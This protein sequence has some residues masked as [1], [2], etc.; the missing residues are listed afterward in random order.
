MKKTSF[1][2]VRMLRCLCLPAV[3]LFA[4]N[5]V[6]AQIA[7]NDNVQ[8]SVPADVTDCSLTVTPDMISEGSNE[9]GYIQIYDNS[10]LIAE[11]TSA[12]FD[13][14]SYLGESL[15]ARVYEGTD[16]TGLFCW[17]SFTPEDKSGPT[18]SMVGAIDIDCDEDI[19]VPGDGIVATDNCSTVAAVQLAD[20]LI[21]DSDPCDDGVAIL[22]RTYIAFDDNGNA[23]APIIQDITINRTGDV[24]FPAD[25]QFNCEQYLADPTI[26]DEGPLSTFVES[27]GLTPITPGSTGLIRDL[28]PFSTAVIAG[29]SAGEVG[30]ASGLYC[31]YAASSTEDTLFVCA[32]SAR[33]F[34]IA[35]TFSVLDWCTGSLLSGASLVDA[36]GDDN[37]QIIKVVDNTDPIITGLPTAPVVVSAN[38]PGQHPVPCT[39]TGAIP[40]P[41]VT[42]CASLPANI[43]LNVFA[44]RDNNNNGLVDAGDDNVGAGIVN[45]T[46]TVITLGNAANPAQGLT[47]GNYVLRYSAGDQC[48]NVADATIQLV[49]V[50]NIQ[51][52]PVC[53]EI[54]TITL[55][56]S[57]LATIPAT[58]FDDGSF[59]NCCLE[60]FLVGKLNPN[61]MTLVPDADP[62]DDDL[63]NSINNQFSSPGNIATFDN[64]FRGTS[65][66]FDCDDVGSNMVELLVYDC[67]GNFNTCM[68]EVIVEDKSLVNLTCPTFAP[69]NCLDFDAIAVQLDATDPDDNAGR[70]AI[71]ESFGFASPLGFGAICGQS[72]DSQISF[73][74]DN[75]GTGTITRTFTTTG[76]NMATASIS[77]DIPVT[78]VPTFRVQ[79]PGDV[80]EVCVDGTIIDVTDTDLLDQLYGVPT[81]LDDGCNMLSYS[82]EVELFE[83]FG[84]GCYKIVR[85]FTAINMCAATAPFND[86]NGFNGGQVY[87]DAD[88]ADNL[89]AGAQI[90]SDAVI[91]YAQVI[92]VDDS[93]APVITNVPALEGCIIGATAT[94]NACALDLV[95]PAP[96]ATDCSMELEIGFLLQ[97][98]G[99]PGVLVAAGTFT[100]AS[101]TISDVAPGDYTVIYNVSDRCG[102]STVTAQDVEVRDCKKPSPVCM[103]G[104]VVEL[105]QTGMISVTVDQIDKGSFDN[106]PGALVLSFAPAGTPGYPVT[107]ATY[108]CSQVGD[109]PIS[110]YVRDAAGNEDFCTTFVRVQDNMFACAGGVPL[111]GGMVA[112]EMNEGVEDVVVEINNLGT[113]VNSTN[114]GSYSVSVDA[115]SDISLVPNKDADAADNGVSTLDIV[116][117][118][119]H[120]LGLQTL[121]SPYKR[122]AADANGSGSISALDIIAIR[123]VI[124]HLD[125]EFTAV[126][127]WR[128]VDA[129]YAFNS[130]TPEN[131]DFP[132]VISLNNV[133]DDM[134]SADFVAVKTGD[135]NGTAATTNAT[136]HNTEDRSN[137]TFVLNAA[138]RKVRAGE[139]FTVEF[140]TADVAVFGY[141]FTMDFNGLELV[142]FEG[143]VAGEDNFGFAFANEGT[144]TSSWNGASAAGSQFALTFVANEAGQLSDMIE[145]NSRLTGAEAYSNAGRLDVNLAFNGAVS[146]EFAL[147]QNVPNPFSA[148]TTIAFN[149]PVAGDAILTIQDVSGKVLSRVAGTYAKGYN[150]ITV[151]ADQLPATGVLYYTLET[152]EHTATNRMVL[153]K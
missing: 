153:N 89:F 120:V 14:S 46:N 135:V 6:S 12:T 106:C 36:D 22:Q 9:G 78:N 123:R 143:G 53:D 69:I 83:N 116:A 3:M 72:D 76:A 34:K 102:N 133:N 98:Q 150:E 29:T 96:T 128:F 41:T 55:P 118:N 43:N 23:S 94:G 97:T 28:T 108:D 26:T 124:L 68:V 152:A 21:I 59:D 73:S 136:A 107:T 113:T 121:D 81:F 75:C 62:N 31:A 126:G 140:T 79:F 88:D 142:D 127:N 110:L 112:T 47:I 40:V 58:A 122:I 61:T 105:M 151:G 48:G 91:R 125:T 93:E 101:T 95:I 37:V 4:F 50:D 33:T 138:D 10:V 71:L 20:E 132:Q 51:P 82:Q 56:N 90:G 65:V 130:N 60:G 87:I 119:R 70:Q 74:L 117:I 114:N 38:N 18:L 111:V 66:A 64:G 109:N 104:I 92:E 129:A 52:T 19:P 49:V 85:T 11:G 145:L 54:T 32:E 67:F 7:C 134:M 30:V 148:E 139:T 146:N 13:A 103:N 24:D 131:E 27:V 149:L 5:G 44:F 100:G 42:D 99:T 39:F 147:Y 35:R 115:G 141:Q 45:S 16:A 57:G 2:F 15:I 86:I 77:C 17:G 144:L 84:S 80:D 1:T 8:I 63:D 137:G 25:I